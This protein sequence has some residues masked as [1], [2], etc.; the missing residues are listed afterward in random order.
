[1]V[2]AF[3]TCIPNFF[4]LSSL[5]CYRADRAGQHT[6]LYMGLGLTLP[7]SRAASAG[8]AIQRS[9]V[10]SS[11]FICPHSIAQ[12]HLVAHRIA[13]FIHTA[14][15]ACCRSCRFIVWSSLGPSFLP[16][17]IAAAAA[18]WAY[19]YERSLPTYHPLGHPLRSLLAAPRL[20]SHS[21]SPA[22]VSSVVCLASV[23]VLH[24]PT[25]PLTRSLLACWLSAAFSSLRTA[26]VQTRV[27]ASPTAPRSSHSHSS[28]S[29]SRSSSSTVTAT[30]SQRPAALRRVPLHLYLEC[31]SAK[32][33]SRHCA[34]QTD[35]REWREEKLQAEFVPCALPAVSGSDAAS[36][37]DHTE[38]FDWDG[39]IDP[40]LLA[41]VDKT[42]LQA[43]LEVQQEEQ[44]A[45]TQRTATDYDNRLAADATR[46]H[47]MEQSDVERSMQHQ[48][49][50]E[51]A[52]ISK[53]AQHRLV[54]QQLAATYDSKNMVEQLQ[55]AVD[56]KVEADLYQQDK[57]SIEKL[58]QHSVLTSSAPLYVDQ[59]NARAALE[60]CLRIQ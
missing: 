52:R 5:H 30:S 21:P 31:Q 15:R 55:R 49:D 44:R 41:I 45:R 23:A 8:T 10:S 58:L 54:S 37:C 18:R 24:C 57:L 7:L 47:Q 20:A 40:L 59:L 29:P 43:A 2:S 53:Q 50:L 27:V 25:H 9:C 19:R 51:T 38:L 36:Q 35:G 26:S 32:P 17:S 60:R 14:L 16:L 48:M 56:D 28:A 13:R 1:M 34:Q 33:A 22:L 12:S 42:L 11:Q 4:Y 39:A 6:L 46:V 3:T